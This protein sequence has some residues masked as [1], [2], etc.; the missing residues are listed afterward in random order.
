MLSGD[1]ATRNT[2]TAPD[3]VVPVTREVSGFGMSNRLSIPPG[4]VAVLRLTGR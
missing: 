1:P 4:S 2:L 3:A